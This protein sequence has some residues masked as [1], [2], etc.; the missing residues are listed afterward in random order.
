MTKMRKAPGALVAG[1]EYGRGSRKAPGG[2]KG[3]AKYR[4]SQKAG[5]P[6]SVQGRMTPLGFPIPA[7]R[8]ASSRTAS[9]K[10]GTRIA[11]AAMGNQRLDA[12]RGAAGVDSVAGGLESTGIPLDDS[13]R[14]RAGQWQ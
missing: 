3:T 2:N 6:R 1:I 12:L 11:V 10:I 9:S 8:N 5:R 13:Q 7:A 14:M 4:L